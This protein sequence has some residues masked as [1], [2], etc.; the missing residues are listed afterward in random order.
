VFAILCTG[1]SMSQAVA[2]SVRHLRVV[3][4]NN[5]YELAPWAEALA[6]NDHAWW[7]KNPE[8]RKF[9]GRKFSTNTILGVERLQAPMLVKS[10]SCS[11]VLALEVAKHLGATRILLYGVDMRGSHYFG[12]YSNGL[13]NTTEERRKIHMRQFAAWGRANPSI[14]VLNA[15][16]GSKLACFPMQKI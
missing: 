13:L 4:V 3:A 6:A 7:R 8:A 2:D 11:G 15:T 9:E 12:E 16:P 5:A 14:E 1:P 10:D